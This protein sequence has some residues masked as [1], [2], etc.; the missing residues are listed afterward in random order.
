[1]SGAGSVHAAMGNGATFNGRQ[2]TPADMVRPPLIASSN[3]QLSRSCVPAPATGHGGFSLPATTS[4]A[5]PIACHSST[6][7]D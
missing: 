5:M 4:I 2:P 7:H 3:E 6:Q 1:M